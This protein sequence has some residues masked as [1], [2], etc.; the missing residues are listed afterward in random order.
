MLGYRSVVVVLVLYQI[1]LGAKGF[2]EDFEGGNVEGDFDEDDYEDDEGK[3]TMPE[4]SSSRLA[5]IWTIY[6]LNFLIC[7]YLFQLTWRYVTGC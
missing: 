2:K 7:D 1:F 5:F 3:L 4:Q 6:H